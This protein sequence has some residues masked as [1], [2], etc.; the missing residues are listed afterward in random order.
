MN[1]SIRKDPKLVVGGAARVQLLPPSVAARVRVRSTRRALVGI[2]VLAMMVSGIGYGLAS[3]A[4]AASAARL[5]A[6]QDRTSVLLAQQGEFI[7]VQRVEERVNTATAARQMGSSTEIAWGDYFTAISA[8]LPADVG[9]TG[10]TVDSATPLQPFAQATA[11]LQGERIATVVFA[12]TSVSIPD[13]A[14]WMD[15]LAGL[16]GYV[17]ATPGSISQQ[18]DGPYEVTV[19]LHID[20]DAL[21]SRFAPEASDITTTEEADK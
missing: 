15:R 11:P 19:T 12:A 16:D 17:D 21:A 18:T 7:E 10:L 1:L 2:V 14:L 9:L 4:V 6:V 8:S 5:L 3:A 20:S 13:V